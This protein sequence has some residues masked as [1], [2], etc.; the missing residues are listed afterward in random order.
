MRLWTLALKLTSSSRGRWRPGTTGTQFSCVT[1]TKLQQ[2]KNTRRGGTGTQFTCCTSTKQVNW[3]PVRICTFT[4]CFASAKQVVAALLQ[5]CY[6]TFTTC[7]ASTKH[8]NWVPVLAHLAFLFLY[9]CTS[10]ASKLSACVH[11]VPTPA[12][13]LT[14]TNIRIFFCLLY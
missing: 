6:S 9:F 3:V 8:V 10:K 12:S 2:K 1:N 5:L 11:A 4:A 14:R 7:F 13:L